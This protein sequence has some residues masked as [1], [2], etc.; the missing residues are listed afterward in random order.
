[1]SE[2]Q[3]ALITGITGQDGSYLAELLVGKGY[4]VVGV[5]TESGKGHLDNLTHVQDQIEL[6]KGEITDRSFLLDQVK[7]HMPDEIYNLASVSSVGSPWEDTEKLVELTALVPLSFLE[8]IRHYEPKTRFFQA[9]SAEMY[10][11]VTESPQTEETPMRPRNPYGLSKVFAHSMVEL[12]RNAHNLFAV[13]GILFNHESSRRRDEFVTKKIVTTLAKVK[14]GDAKE[15]TIGNLEAQ[16]D[17]SFAGDIVEAMW[18]ALQH[19]R[20]LSYVLASGQVHTVREFIEVAASVLSLSLTW[21]GEKENEIGKNEKGDIIVRVDPKFY[22]P[23]EV[24]VRQGDIS[25]IK[26]ELGWTPKTSFEELVRLM[27]ME[28]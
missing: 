21:E 8:I 27:V 20:P 5:T 4:R 24:H 25:R 3:T 1:M 17:W 7:T 19:D 26:K 28:K 13:S 16:R 6:I 2:Q 18:R 15:L 9:S 22:R 11:D 23:A 14:Q 12:Y 10:G